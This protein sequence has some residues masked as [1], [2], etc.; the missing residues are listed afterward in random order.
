M[1]DDRARLPES[2]HLSVLASGLSL[3]LASALSQPQYDAL[4]A[5]LSAAVGVW[6]SNFMTYVVPQSQSLHTMAMLLTKQHR[7][8]GCV[9]ALH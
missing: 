3:Y 1:A 5:E 2:K 6:L 7:S 8:V 4:S 9:H